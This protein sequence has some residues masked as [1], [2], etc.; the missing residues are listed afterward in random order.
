MSANRNA[1]LPPLLLILVLIHDS[2]ANTVSSQNRSYTTSQPP[3]THRRIIFV[4]EPEEPETPMA[5]A[6]SRPAVLAEL[7]DYDP[8]RDQ[9]TPCT[10]LSF[11]SGCLCP[12]L[13]GPN[14]LPQAP[15]LK[16][17]HREGSEV[18]ARWCAPASEV[19]QYRV[20][21]EPG[22]FQLFEEISRKGSLGNLV[23]GTKV[24]VEAI[25]RAGISNPSKYSCTRYEPKGTDNLALKAGLIAGGLILLLLL[26]V[27]AFLLWRRKLH[28]EGSG[29]V[30]L[31][32]PSFS[33]E[34]TL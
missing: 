18:V 13:S 12:G 23:P 11:E 4:A 10:Q 24:C 32:N 8:C 1:A 30:G 27:V 22:I 9:Q 28:K 6:S 16:S 14:V 2:V 3:V 34:G 19:Q 33:T 25:N 26:S 7:C 31:G 15:H 20:T 17:V 5:R 21:V 29:S